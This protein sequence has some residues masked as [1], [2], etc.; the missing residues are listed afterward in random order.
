M[1]GRLPPS[2]GCATKMPRMVGKGWTITS[3]L[4]SVGAGIPA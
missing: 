3:N 1:Q 4:T 2:I